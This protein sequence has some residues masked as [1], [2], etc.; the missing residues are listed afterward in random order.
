[1][2]LI[3][4]RDF[5]GNCSDNDKND[6]SDLLFFVVFFLYGCDFITQQ[7]EPHKLKY[8]SLQRCL[9][10]GLSQK[11]VSEHKLSQNVFVKNYVALCY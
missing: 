1:M 8:C 6:K 5:L 3:I 9:F 11:H 4:Y 2:D 7:S 10:L